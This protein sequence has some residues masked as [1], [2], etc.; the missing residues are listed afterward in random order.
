M[1]VIF[2]VVL[3]VVKPYSVVVGY[4]HFRGPYCPYLQSD[5]RIVKYDIFSVEIVFGEIWVAKYCSKFP[6]IFKNLLLFEVSS[7]FFIWICTSQL[8]EHIYLSQNTC[9]IIYMVYT[10]KFQCQVRY[11]D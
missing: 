6:K 5:F 8:C 10:L 11:S 9:I 1:A 3:W 4:Q 2:Q 7:F